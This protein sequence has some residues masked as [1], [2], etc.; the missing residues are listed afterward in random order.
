MSTS[1]KQQTNTAKTRKEWPTPK[2]LTVVEAHVLSYKKTLTT[3]EAVAL[4]LHIAAPE[5]PTGAID[6]YT[7]IARALLQYAEREKLNNFEEITP[8]QTEHFITKETHGLAFLATEETHLRRNLLMLI[9]LACNMRGI[10]LPRHAANV[11]NLKPRVGG[12]RRPLTDD[13]ILLARLASKYKPFQGPSLSQTG[14]DTRTLR[15]AL[16]G[17]VES[18]A[19]SGELAELTPRHITSNG[20]NMHVNLAGTRDAHP[21]RVEL[22][23]WATNQ[24]RDLQTQLNPDPERNPGLF[25]NG[26]HPPRSNEAQGSTSGV[27]SEILQYAGLK[28]IGIKA[29]QAPFWHARAIFNQTQKL[30]DA[31]QILGSTSLKTITLLG[32][33]PDHLNGTSQKKQNEFTQELAA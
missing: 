27:L 2:T 14:R 16:W 7:N 10:N 3:V 21:R 24:Y 29:L 33:N 8:E 15:A 17:I 18:G 26:Q 31:A 13:E 30:T 5:S 9:H 1:T 23:T 25:Y 6:T 32:I 20:I 12:A 22:T 11:T 28:Q 19:G 4:A